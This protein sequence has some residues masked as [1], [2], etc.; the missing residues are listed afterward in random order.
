MK[1][2]E[3]IRA[4]VRVLPLASLSVTVAFIKPRPFGVRTLPDTET[5]AAVGARTVMIAACE[6]T[7]APGLLTRTS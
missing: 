6:V 5:F 4:R 3:L 7:I 1:V 2:A